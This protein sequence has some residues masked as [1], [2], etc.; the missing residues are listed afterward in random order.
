M[1]ASAYGCGAVAG[2]RLEELDIQRMEY[3]G[4]RKIMDCAELTFA[5]HVASLRLELSRPLARQWL[6]PGVRVSPYG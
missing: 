4:G 5:S 1:V 3:P 2:E 6:R